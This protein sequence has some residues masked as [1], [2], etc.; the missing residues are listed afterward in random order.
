MSARIRIAE[1]ERTAMSNHAASAF[2]NECCGVLLGTR[3]SEQEWQ[4][5]GSRPSR[6]V[7]TGDPHRTFEIDPALLIRTQKELRGTET[8]IIGYYHSHPKGPARP[9][10]T[11]IKSVLEAD[12]IWL[13]AG[14]SGETGETEWG[15]FMSIQSENGFR[16]EP[17]ELIIERA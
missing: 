12:K 14:Y 11:D 6:N 5:S 4:V 3:Q 10:E 16:F 8:S 7:T 9:S 13:I 2:P 1:T 15:A 17:A